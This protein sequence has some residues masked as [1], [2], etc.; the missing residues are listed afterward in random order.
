MSHIL[1]A[2]R[3]P[4]ALVVLVVSFVSGITLAI[5]LLPLGL[6]AYIMMVALAASDS[7]FVTRSTRSAA[8]ANI[9][10]RTFRD[11]L[12]EIDR[13]QRAVQDSID[14]AT[15]PIKRLLE[16]IGEQTQQLVDQAHMLANK[17]QI[18][19][20]FLAQMDYAK[21][22]QQIDKIDEKIEQTT[23]T[24]TIQQLEETRKALVNRRKNAQDLETFIGR[25]TAQLQNI[26]ANL[27][28]T[29]SETIRLRTADA[30]SANSSSN[31]IADHLSNLNA[32]MSAFRQVLD[33]TM[34]QSGAMGQNP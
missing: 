16:P 5:W 15:G 21:L 1:T 9:R 13:S 22:R 10:N 34:L 17:G 19:E 26:D 28:N 7:S 24:Y 33:T 3:Q 20:A 12:A 11:L 25:I 6:L 27:D 23:D 14:Q 29:L 30:I 32:D 4:L 8:R 2:A 31:Q 18:I